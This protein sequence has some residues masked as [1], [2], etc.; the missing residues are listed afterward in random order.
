L[1]YED[2]DA[3]DNQILDGDTYEPFVVDVK[4]LFPVYVDMLPTYSEITIAN[5]PVIQPQ[6]A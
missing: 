3:L 1:E 5:T 2:A 6:L 4:Y